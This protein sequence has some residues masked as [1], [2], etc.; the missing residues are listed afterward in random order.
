MLRAP[1]KNMID[2]RRGILKV[3]IFLCVSITLG[4]I[5]VFRPAIF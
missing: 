5:W 3:D 2:Q 1:E 4:P